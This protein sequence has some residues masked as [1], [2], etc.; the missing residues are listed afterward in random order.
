M[1]LVEEESVGFLKGSRY[2]I[3]RA[4]LHFVAA[5]HDHAGGRRTGLIKTPFQD[6][7]ANA[8]A[9]QLVGSFNEECL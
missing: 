6:P 2:L 8:N 4:R 5:L 3:S 9:K 7:D 1:G